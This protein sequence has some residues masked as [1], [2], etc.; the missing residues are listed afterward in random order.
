ML[1]SVLPSQS[2]LNCSTASALPLKQIP[3]ATAEMIA[4][5]FLLEKI[6]S[7]HSLLEKNSENSFNFIICTLSNFMTKNFLQKKSSAREVKIFKILLCYC[8]F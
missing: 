4:F 3:A 2:I 6:S 8:Q 7:F 5:F 1:K